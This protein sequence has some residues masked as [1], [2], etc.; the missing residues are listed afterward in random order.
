MGKENKWMYEF[1]LLYVRGYSSSYLPS[2]LLHSSTYSNTVLVEY[3][4]VLCLII[5]LCF[6][7]L[8]IRYSLYLCY[9]SLLILQLLRL[10][11]NVVEVWQI[12]IW[13]SR[14]SVMRHWTDSQRCWTT[15]TAVGGSWQQRWKSS[16]SSATGTMLQ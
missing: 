13:A 8:Y 14:P 2:V 7:K 15:Q 10:W 6:I 12:G 16:H 3:D 5:W 9:I 1:H 11:E 4:S